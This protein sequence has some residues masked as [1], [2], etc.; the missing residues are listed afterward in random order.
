MQHGEARSPLRRAPSHCCASRA[1]DEPKAMMQ[2]VDLESGRGHGEVTRT[3]SMSK[4][5][6]TMTDA[7]TAAM[8]ESMVER[9]VASVV[10]S[11]VRVLK[12]IV[13]GSTDSAMDMH[14]RFY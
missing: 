7:E 2:P 13:R 9:A 5:D 6:D 12:C 1:G 4:L 14:D 11:A 8:I 10:T 3:T